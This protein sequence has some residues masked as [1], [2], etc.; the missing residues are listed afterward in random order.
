MP[1]KTMFG[2]IVQEYERAQNKE[3]TTKRISKLANITEEGIIEIL[4][5]TFSV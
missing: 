2:D 1:K 5:S 4:N 3:M